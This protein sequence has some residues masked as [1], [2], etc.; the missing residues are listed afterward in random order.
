[1]DGGCNGGN[2]ETAFTYVH[3]AG[4]IETNKNYPY[5]SGTGITGICKFKKGMQALAS[6]VEAVVL[7]CCPHLVLVC[8]FAASY[9]LVLIY[10]SQGQHNHFGLHQGRNG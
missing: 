2:T 3:R 1:M 7:A 4:G 5:T 9:L 10:Y 8:D 6:S